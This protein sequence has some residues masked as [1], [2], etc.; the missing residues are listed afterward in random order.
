MESCVLFSYL[1]PLLPTYVRLS[2]QG[3]NFV[4]LDNNVK[5]AKQD[6]IGCGVPVDQPE[7]NTYV[8]TV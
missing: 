5:H 3:T 1:S 8:I 6:S 4:I 7:Q 2:E